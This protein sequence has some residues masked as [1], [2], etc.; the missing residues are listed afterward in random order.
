MEFLKSGTFW[1]IAG[2]CLVVGGVLIALR[3][4]PLE[5]WIEVFIAWSERLGAAGKFIFVAVYM[6]AMVACVWG[7]PFTV[8][9]GLAFGV[10]WGTVVATAGATGGS[11]VAFLIA[12]YV[13]RDA[14]A[15]WAERHAKFKA[16]DR[17]LEQG[18]WKIVFL[19]RFSPMIPFSISN[20]LFGLTRIS[21]GAFFWA[22]LL[23]I[24]PGSFAVAY[25]GHMGRMSLRGGIEDLDAISIAM[26]T[27]AA[28][29][30][31]AVVIYFTLLARKQLARV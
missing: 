31:I 22:S 28:V 27:A 25:L 6:A 5:P 14:L 10:W 9:A 24:L 11:A 2:L 3:F 29:M 19:T 17:A 15:R 30:T 20:Y 7:T 13:A 26:M 1:K 16:I 8:A 18:G 23:A 21:F 4:L 12:R